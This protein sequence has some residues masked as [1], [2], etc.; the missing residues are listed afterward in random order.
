MNKEIKYLRKKFFILSALI[1]VTLIF[2]MVLI[3]NILMQFSYK[4]ELKNST[5]MLLQT[6]FSNV[7]DTSS[8]LVLLKDTEI[9]NIGDNIIYRNPSTIKKIVLNG[10]IT[11]TDENAEWYCAGGGLFFELPDKKGNIIYIHKEYIFNRD[12]TKITIDFTDNSDFLCNG[13]SVETDITKVSQNQFYVSKVWWASS[14]MKQVMKPNET[15][16][17]ELESVEIYYLDNTYL[18]SSE[19][20]VPLIRNFNDIYP[21]GISDTL[22]A[23]NCFYFISDKQGNIVEI[24][25]GNSTE[26]FSQEQAL[27]MMNS[28]N[29]E[30][31]SDNKKYKR[32]VNSNDEFII[33]SFISNAQ[34]E[35]N[36]NKLIIVSALSGGGVFVLVLILIYFISGKV[37]KPISESYQ[38]QKEFISNVSHELKTPITVITASTELIEKK[39]GSD[40]LTDCIQAQS[41]KMSR[42]VNEMLTLTRFSEFEKQRGEFKQFNIS[43]IV[44]NSVLYFESRA[45][46]EGKRIQS[47]INENL[48]YT[49][50]VDKID[51]LIGIL[52]DNAL[53]Y[54]DEH[55]EIK[56]R[57]YSEKENIILTCENPCKNFNTDD[58][59]R[60]FERFYRADKSRSN[61]KEGFGLGLSIA[62][63][64]V[65]IHNSTIHAEYKN[66]MVIFNLTLKKLAPN[67]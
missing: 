42:L 32:T 46:E 24:N 49:G 26:F 57:L 21:T 38:K 41:Q 9:N 28:E 25:N 66:D 50:N 60:M 6:A 53:K 59:S 1:S 3:L 29:S 8:E 36:T 14:S 51:E 15:V 27:K 40:K 2:I 23:Y 7:S 11:C 5:E 62:K 54:S 35:H 18:A 43:Q 31:T 48:I 10:I 39:K 45:F 13:L 30:W 17:L 4:N 47:N 16:K 63:E 12:E 67:I 19:N 61:E 56:I 55:A 37:V 20:F 58:I 22:Q 65:D 64:I 52:L 34:A 44:S 33:Y